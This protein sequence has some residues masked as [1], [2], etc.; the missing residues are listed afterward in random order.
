M[1]CWFRENLQP[2]MNNFYMNVVSKTGY[3]F[4]NRVA[5]IASNKSWLESGLGMFVVGV[6]Q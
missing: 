1:R 2:D 3:S 5:M 4:Y 6:S